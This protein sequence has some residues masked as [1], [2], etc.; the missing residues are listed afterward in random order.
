MRRS[1]SL[2]QS[3]LTLLAVWL[4][5]YRESSRAYCQ[6]LNPCLLRVHGVKSPTI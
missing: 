1:L 6:Q 3:L 4:G 5:V 2:G